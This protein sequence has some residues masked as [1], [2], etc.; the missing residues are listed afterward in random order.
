MDGVWSNLV[1][2]RQKFMNEFMGGE[3]EQIEKKWRYLQ[4]NGPKEKE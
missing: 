3:L 1:L 4:A 2:D